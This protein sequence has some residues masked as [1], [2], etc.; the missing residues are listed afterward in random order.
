MRQISAI[1]DQIDG[2]K[3]YV[4]FISGGTIVFPFPEAFEKGELI[5]R[6]D[7]HYNQ[8]NDEEP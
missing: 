1:I 3:V 4:D 7:N 5:T 8:W 2:S 6:K